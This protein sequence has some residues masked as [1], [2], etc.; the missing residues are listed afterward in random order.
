MRQEGTHVVEMER[1]IEMDGIW[2]GDERKGCKSKNGDRM[3]MKM[4]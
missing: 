1:A 3:E 2:T 4:D